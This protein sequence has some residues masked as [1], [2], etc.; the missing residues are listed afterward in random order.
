[1]TQRLSDFLQNNKFI[2]EFE[3]YQ[4][5]N[6][7]Y[8]FPSLDVDFFN[9]WKDQIDPQD[10]RDFEDF[11][12]SESVPSDKTPSNPIDFSSDLRNN[13]QV[14]DTKTVGVFISKS[15][16]IVSA[17]GLVSANKSRSSS[18]S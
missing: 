9:R 3:K 15:S 1:M 10:H 7:Q 5:N 2:Q 16:S 12:I 18:S 11:L 14:N 13:C 6:T 4:K 8:F 17:L